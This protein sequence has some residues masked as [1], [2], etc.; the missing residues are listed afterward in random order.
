MAILEKLF[1]KKQSVIGLDIGS[2]SIK[3]VQL[4]KE[5]GVPVLET[6][7]TI[8]LGPSFDKSVGQNVVANEKELVSLLNTLFNS[9]NVT[10]KKVGVSIP[11]NSS[12]IS[13]IDLPP[14]SD[15]SITKTMPFEA[16]KHI[17]IPLSEVSIDWFIIPN[18]LLDSD[19]AP[20]FDKTTTPYLQKEDTRKVLLIAIHNKEL[21][22]FKKVIDGLKLEAGFFEIEIFSALRSVTH[23][24]RFPILI[25]DVGARTTKYYILDRGIVR[26]SYYINSGGQKITEVFQ[27]TKN[28]SFEDAEIF[29][30]KHGLNIENED[31]KKNVK[32]LLRDI[33]TEGVNVVKNFEIKNRKTVGKV[34]L[35]GGGV[36]MKG[37]L[38]ESKKSF[39]IEV[40]LADTFSRLQYP[41]FLT[42]SLKVAGPQYA[43]S[44]GAA[45]RMLDL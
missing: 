13:L 42:D 37:F 17:P 22:K 12:L 29:K 34:I 10:S 39:D 11:F 9:A 23:E 5:K 41:A 32:S 19:E 33:F 28:I 25:I 44:I 27:N 31:V 20:I 35:T 21:I 30:R 4:K 36:V 38:E 26:T 15:D 16:K 18:A 8:A 14:L 7:G 1:R 43:V 6:Y 40:E 24:N 45:L 2:A 3:V